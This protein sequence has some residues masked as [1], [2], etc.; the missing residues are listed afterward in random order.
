LHDLAPSDLAIDSKAARLRSRQD[1]DR[2][3][4]EPEIRTRAMVM[5]QKTNSS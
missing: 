1:P 2:E 3:L 5:Q 4:V